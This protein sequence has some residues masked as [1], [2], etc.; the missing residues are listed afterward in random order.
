MVSWSHSHNVFSDHK[1]AGVLLS[2]TSRHEGV[3]RNNIFC[4]P[5]V[6]CEE[7]FQHLVLPTFLSVLT[8]LSLPHKTKDREE[9]TGLYNAVWLPSKGTEGQFLQQLY[10]M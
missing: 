4:L 3:R 5:N 9:C 7:H 10:E 2:L 1:V 6:I 8:N